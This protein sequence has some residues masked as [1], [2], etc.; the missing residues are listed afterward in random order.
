MKS[1]FI[2]CIKNQNINITDLPK[3]IIVGL[4]FV[5]VSRREVD[6]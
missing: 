1:T 3:I 2:S 6:L 4:E 5:F